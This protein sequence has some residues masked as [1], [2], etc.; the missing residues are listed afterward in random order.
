MNIIAFYSFESFTA[1]L[2]FI[3]PLFLL[4]DSNMAIVFI[5]G[6]GSEHGR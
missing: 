4:A 5:T 3:K 6:Y 2:K 1:K